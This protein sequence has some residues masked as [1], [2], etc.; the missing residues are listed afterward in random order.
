MFLYVMITLFV[1]LIVQAFLKN[2][3]TPENLFGATGEFDKLSRK[4]IGVSTQEK[5]TKAYIEPADFIGD[6]ASTKNKFLASITEETYE[7]I[8]DQEYYV[9]LVFIEKNLRIRDDVEVFFDEEKKSI[10]YRGL[11]RV[12]LLDFGRN[13]KRY[14]NI[15]KNYTSSRISNG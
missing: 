2:S 12:G 13:K 7:K 3:M 4:T 6:V 1:I 10:H 11:A 8:V 14:K 15:V 5:G 9:H